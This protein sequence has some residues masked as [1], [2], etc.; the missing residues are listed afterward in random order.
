MKKFYYILLV[1]MSTVLFSACES[2]QLA[3][4]RAESQIYFYDLPLYKDSTLISFARL[5]PGTKETLIEIPLRYIGPVVDFDRTF[6]VS[7]DR[8]HTTAVE[9]KDYVLLPDM[10]RIK[11]GAS[12]GVLPVKIL[13]TPD[14]DETTLQLVLQLEA[15]ENFNTH[16]NFTNYDLNPIDLS[17][18]RIFFS[19]ML[20]KPSW[21]TGSAEMTYLGDFSLKKVEVIFFVTQKNLDEIE[22]SL[23]R[24]V[25][26]LRAI[27]REV[28]IHINYNRSI[29]EEILDEN[30][31][32]INMG[33]YV[34]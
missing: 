5:E 19:N 11:G 27:A 8:E 4:F 22:K 17:R 29:G 28:Q 6:K 33:S 25:D 34:N 14:L 12:N 1:M 31:R 32:A 18:Y 15:N 16:V 9:G 2:S 30:G 24:G 3:P 10:Y 7:V 13:S 21:W 20:L 26:L 23:V